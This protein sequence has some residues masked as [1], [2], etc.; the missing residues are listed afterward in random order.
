MGIIRFSHSS[1]DI[2]RI[3]EDPPSPIKNISKEAI[4]RCKTRRG[5]KALRA[6]T[7]VMREVEFSDLDV[8]FATFSNLH[9]KWRL[10]CFV[11]EPAKGPFEVSVP[12]A[13]DEGVQHGGDDS[14][15]H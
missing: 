4:F 3:P 6:T 1:S 11:E 2:C 14:V 8:N 9:S 5:K 10:D 13:V 15:H 7:N 12:Q